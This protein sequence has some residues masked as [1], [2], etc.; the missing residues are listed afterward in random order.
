MKKQQDNNDKLKEKEYV[1]QQIELD[2]SFK[3]NKKREELDEKKQKINDFLNE[4]QMINENKVYINDN[5]NNEYN[6]YS[7]KINEMMYKRPMDKS[8]LNNIQEMFYDNQKLAGMIQN[9]DK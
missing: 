5:F 2:D 3:R 1:I 7:K 4:K 8:S 9:I 6:F